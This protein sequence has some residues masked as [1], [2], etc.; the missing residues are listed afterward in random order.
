MLAGTASWIASSTG[1]RSADTSNST[2]SPFIDTFCRPDLSPCDFKNQ[3]GA[4][5]PCFIDIVI[6]C[7]LPQ[8]PLRQKC[9]LWLPSP[10]IY[11]LFR[12]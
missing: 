1:L 12:I 7:A 2:S 5:T 11:Y 6:I 9:F 3:L 8:P 10:S 4:F